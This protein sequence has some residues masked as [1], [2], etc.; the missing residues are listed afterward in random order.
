MVWRDLLMGVA[1]LL[2]MAACLMSGPTETRRSMSDFFVGVLKP[3]MADLGANP[4][5]LFGEVS[6]SVWPL[7]TRGRDDQSE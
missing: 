7:P 5:S 1:L 6:M 2:S 4:D 3:S